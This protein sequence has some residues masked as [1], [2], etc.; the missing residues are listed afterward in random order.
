MKALREAFGES[1]IDLEKEF[2]R[3]IVISCDLQSATGIK[4]FFE[5]FPKKSLEVGIS[6]ANAVGI[7]AGLALSGYKPILTSFGSFLSGKNTEIR[8]SIGYNAANVILV[9][10]HGGLIGPDGATQSG[11]QDIAVMRSI[12]GMRVYQ[13]ATPIEVREI[14]KYVLQNNSPSYLRIARNEVPEIHTQDFKFVEGQVYEVK[15]GTDVVIFSSGPILHNCLKAAKELLGEIDVRVIN[16]PTIKPL[17]I[18]SLGKAFDGVKF[19]VSFEDHLTT[20]GL[21]SAIIETLS[22]SKGFPG[23]V[24]EGLKD[25]F[26]DSGKPI[27]LEK[28]FKLDSDS[29]TATIRRLWKDFV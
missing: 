8:I 15:S 24:I 4:P 10:T 22:N 3:M 5:K 7:A 16:V 1:L 27:D 2:A 6:E 11:I 13:P 17:D 29:I 20:G 9:G 25:E 26:V 18:T 12:P 14:I 19:A 21:G 28:Y 23:L